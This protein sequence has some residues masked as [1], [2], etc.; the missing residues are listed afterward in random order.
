MVNFY[1]RFTPGIAAVLELLTGALKGG[2]KTLEWTPALDS[3]FQHSKQVLA[4]VVQL[5]HPAPNSADAL[6]TD[7]SNTHIG[8]TSTNRFEALG[9]H[10]VPFPTS[11]NL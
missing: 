3:A 9:S 10:W 4:A 8:S 5:A 7:A 2:K 1:C 6:A 11:Y